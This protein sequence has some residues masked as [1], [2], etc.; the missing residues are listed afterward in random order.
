VRQPKTA[1]LAPNPAP[2]APPEPTWTPEATVA[3]KLA[4]LPKP[5]E[6]EPRRMPNWDG[7]RGANELPDARWEHATPPPPRRQPERPPAKV[8][9][10]ER[11]ARDKAFTVKAALAALL[12][13]FLTVTVVMVLLRHSGTTPTQSAPAVVVAPSDVARVQASTR[14]LNA[15][16]AATRTAL[17]QLPGIPTPLNVGAVINP[18]VASL[19]SYGTFL[20]TARLPGGPRTA[21]ALTHA[22]VT[23]DLQHLETINGLPALKL[24]SYLEQFTQDAARFQGALDSLQQSLADSTR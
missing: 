7:A 15:E 20:T 6:V 5:T 13:V 14:E 2:D 24:G 11:P 9:S 22:L 19:Q 23:Q 1:R 16:T 8:S 3:P 18:Y 4:T 21:A 10:P 12:V 17:H